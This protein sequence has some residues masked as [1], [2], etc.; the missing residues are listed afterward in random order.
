MTESIYLSAYEADPRYRGP[1]FDKAAIAEAALEQYED[2][3]EPSS[4]LESF[5][6]DKLSYMDG[7]EAGP[8]PVNSPDE[9]YKR[10]GGGD[11]PYEKVSGYGEPVGTSVYLE[12]VRE[13]N[14]RE[15]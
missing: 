6:S 13:Q 15:S 10:Y 11:E 2:I 9:I 7:C 3:S 5:R 12:Y 14:L 8:D 1:V 4:Y